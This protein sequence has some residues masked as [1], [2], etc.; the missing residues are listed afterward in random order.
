MI[1]VTDPRTVVVLGRTPASSAR[2]LLMGVEHG[3]NASLIALGI[4]PTAAQRLV[5]E[6][7]LSLAAERRFTLTVETVTDTATLGDRL[8]AARMVVSATKGERRRWHLAG[9]G[10]IDSG[11]R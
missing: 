4:R 7:A 6:E 2:E 3:G 10:V 1:T 9:D 11:A 8:Q 5:T